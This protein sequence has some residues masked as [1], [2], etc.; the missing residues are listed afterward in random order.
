SVCETSCPLGVCKPLYEFNMRGF[1]T[2]E[3]QRLR[4]QDM[5]HLFQLNNCILA[6]KWD[7]FAEK[8]NLYETNV[9]AHIMSP[10]FSVD[11]NTKTD[12]MIAQYILQGI[13]H[14]RKKRKPVRQSLSDDN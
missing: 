10:L 5:P 1:L 3:Q 11:I 6:A 14:D 7:V 13:L 12:L 9:I 2:P 8:K 4:R